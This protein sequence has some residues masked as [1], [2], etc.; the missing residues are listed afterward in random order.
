MFPAMS[1]VPNID[2]C[3][4]DI[5]VAI[6]E[7]CSFD[8]VRNL[9]FNSRRFYSHCVPVLYRHVDLSFHNRSK[10]DFAY[11]HS[12]QMDY[13]VCGLD[14]TPAR[15]QTGRTVR[16]TFDLYN[17]FERVGDIQ[18]K[19]EKFLQTLLAHPEYAPYVRSLSWTLLSWKH[20]V[21]TSI[22]LQEKTPNSIKHIWN[23]LRT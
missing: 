8:G 13:G 20:D 11:R 19:Q 1:S 16:I 3:P 14:E 22:Q 2:G 7:Y 12:T 6:A 5:H 4:A 10:I 15:T 21:P 9:C 18:P 23:V 17:R